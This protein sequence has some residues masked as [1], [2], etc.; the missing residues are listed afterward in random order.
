MLEWKECTIADLGQIITGRTPPTK[1]NKYWNGSVMFVTPKDIQSTKH[2][3]HT[4]RYISELGKLKMSGCVLPKNAVCVSCI[5]NIGYLGITTQECISNQQ[6]NSIIV[7]ENNDI[8]YVYYLLKSL[9]VYFKHCEG[10]STALSILNKTQFSQI[11]VKIPTVKIQKKIASILSALDDKIELNNKINKNLEEQAQAIFKSWF[12]DFEPFGGVMP[13][14][15][16][17]GKVSEIIELHDSKR[18]PLSGNERDK[19]AKNYPYYGATSI[20]D[21]VDNYLFDGI[22]LLLGEDGTVINSK[23]FPILQYVYGK[24]CVNNHAHIITGKSGYSVEMLYLLFNITNVRHIVTGAVQQ[25]ISQI[26]LKNVSVIIPQENI[27][28]DFDKIIQPFFAVIRK[29]RDENQRLSAIR[30]TLLP[31]LLNGKIEIP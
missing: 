3:F 20:I 7:N 22:Y 10:Q 11:K 21:Y 30:D 26:H 24:F 13:D 17:M 25:R 29:N 15:W 4:E 28:K 31:Q 9:W 19:M 12:V 14:N 6:I 18:V 16:R 5:G 8:D 27:L 2:I 23:G 1:N